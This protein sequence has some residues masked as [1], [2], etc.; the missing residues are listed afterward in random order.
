MKIDRTSLLFSA[1]IFC[2]PF[3]LGA[4]SSSNSPVPTADRVEQIIAHQLR[5][6]VAKVKPSAC[7]EELGADELD[8]IE[9]GMSLEEAFDKTIPDEQRESFKTVGQVIDYAVS[10]ESAANP[11]W[12]ARACIRRA[13]QR[14]K[15]ERKELSQRCEWLKK[16]AQERTFDPLWVMASQGHPEIRESAERDAARWRT[17]DCS[18][19]TPGNP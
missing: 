8:M 13:E 18:T 12:H 3:A 14:K 7:L 4:S 15:S 2:A 6:D 10:G 11:G 16:M 9:M 19:W 5:I 1:L 17:V